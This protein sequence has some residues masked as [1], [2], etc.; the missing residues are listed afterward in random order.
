MYNTNI[1]ILILV[2]LP[3]A[4]PTGFALAV[5]QDA[6]ADT[7]EINESVNI[8]NITE[9]SNETTVLE[10]SIREEQNKASPGFPIIDSVISLIIAVLI[11]VSI[12]CIRKN[13]K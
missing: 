10:T 13:I 6:N 7:I 5:N 12:T 1:L 8:I 9:N 4:T 3:I 11:I 2:M